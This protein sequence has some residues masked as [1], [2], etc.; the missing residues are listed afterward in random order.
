MLRY[1]ETVKNGKETA[2]VAIRIRSD[3]EIWAE[4]REELKWDQCI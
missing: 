1:V 3:E 2:N 4:G